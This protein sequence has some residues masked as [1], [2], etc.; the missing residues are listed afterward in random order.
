MAGGVTLHAL[1]T[2][3]NDG[4]AP[5]ELPELSDPSIAP[6]KRAAML[7]TLPAGALRWSGSPLERSVRACFEGHSPHQVWLAAANLLGREGRADWIDHLAGQL[8]R[9]QHRL[10][11]HFW[12]W[13]V[14]DAVSYLRIHPTESAVVREKLIAVRAKADPLMKAGL[15]QIL[16]AVGKVE[17]CD[18]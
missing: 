8:A 12:G 3:M 18:L 9:G 10:P 1:C 4:M 6:T 13:L 7:E 15:N 16:E 17:T 5:L 2:A 11:K 14:F